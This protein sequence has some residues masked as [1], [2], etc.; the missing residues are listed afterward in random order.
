[1]V[2]VRSNQSAQVVLWTLCA[3]LLTTAHAWAQG[4]TTGSIR[5]TVQDSSGGVLPGATVTLTNTGTKAMQ[6]AVSDGRGQFILGGIFP[7]TYDMKVE[8]SGFKSYEQKAIA[9]S[10]TDNRGIDVKLE[11]GAQSETVTVTSQAEII[12]TE[13]GAREG[14]IT[15]KQI[16]NLSIIGRSALELMRILPG[17]VTEFNVGESVSFG[18]GGNNTQG[19]TVNGIRASSNT[20]SLDGSSLIDIGS[21]NGVIVSL[22]TD[23]VQEVKVQ[24]S[25]F[26]AE[27]GTG[28]LNV[29]GVTKSGT[30]KFHGTLYDYWRDHK[31]AANDASNVTA[32]TAKPKSTYQ[33]PGGNIG[34]PI[35]VRRQLHEEPG[36]AVLLRRVRGAAA[37]GRLRVALHTDVFGRHEERRLQRAA[38]QPWLQPE[39]HPAAAHP[40][41]LSRTPAQNAPNND[42]RP[43]MT[44]TGRYFASLY[45]R[46]NYVDPANLYNY[47]YSQL[48]PTNR[49]DFKG[50]FDW[51][52]S[53]STRAYVRIAN[54]GETVES[55]RG[56]WW[57][58]A[59]VVALPTPNVGE[60][61][62]RSYAGNIVSVLS[63][64]MT[65]EVLVSFSR[66]TLDNHF[67][68]PNLLKQGAGGI[69]F[70]GIFP[71]AISSPY[72]PTDLL[73]GWGGSGQVGQLWAKANDMF[74]HN[75][76]LQFSNK[77]TKL[78]GS[79]GLKFGVSIER[80]QKQQNFQNIEAGQLWFGTDNTTGTGNS[81]ADML[82]GRVGQFTQGTAR[83]GNPAPGQPCRQVAVLELR[84]LRAGRL[85]AALEPDARVRCPLRIL[86]QQQGAERPRRLF[87][88]GPLQPERGIVPGPRD[89][90]APERRL[91][92]L[93]RLRAGGHPRQ[94]LAVR[95]AARQRRV[96]H[97]RRGQQRAPRR[98]RHV[99]QPEHGQR[100]IRQHAAHAAELVPGGDG[101]L[102]RRR[103]RWRRRSDLRHD[104][105]GDV[106][107]PHRQHR[108]QLADAGFVH[109]AEDAQLQHLLRAP[110]PVESGRRGCVRRDPG[111][112]PRQ[113]EQRQRHAVWRDGHRNVQ[114]R[115]HD[116]AGEPRVG[117]ERRR[118][119]GGVP[120]LQRAEPASR[121]TTSEA[122][123]TTTRCR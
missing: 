28:G 111:S 95:A 88:A 122:S 115:R 22:N 10:P 54:E 120:A 62:G 9:I 37:A 14:L 46:A 21:N 109:V 123:R 93:H 114:R 113:P 86:D 2:R 45:P 15:A 78:A 83:N 52:I 75:D 63:P 90:P 38:G 91:L 89:L 61:K 26:A 33:Y 4:S 119:P 43:Y 30:S 107:Q 8:L 11:V 36:P 116:R 110:H 42:M 5:G 34:G 16:D 13:T 53:N 104:Q 31:F 118:Q 7:G 58:P 65:N 25:N 27:Y 96:G 1:M 105:R 57:A 98:L 81:G 51:T 69:T 84:R 19:Y 49:H 44:A 59:D 103:L 79:H 40:A 32:G 76:A 67:K 70:R 82:V 41:G 97:R 18:G 29:S 66:L 80:G 94:P 108:H 101:F 100:R 23:M 17:V 102:G 55:S 77:L 60:N 106:R 48:E 92:R 112:R 64:T 74:A 56:V 47:V 117:R 99:L 68:D 50:R 39:Q 85:E 20:V 87:H 12:Q 6:N 121:S 35:I 73:H 24:S 72:L 71:A 3:L